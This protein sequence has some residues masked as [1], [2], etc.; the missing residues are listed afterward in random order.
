MIHF[1]KYNLIGVLNTGITLLVVWILYRQFNLNLELSNFLGFVAGGI[2]SYLLNR[3]WNFKSRNRKRKEI[4]RFLL[5]FAIAYGL[6][7]MVLEFLHRCLLPMDFF[8]PF[9]EWISHYVSPG[10]FANIIANIVYVV[11]SFTLYR[12]FVFRV[13][14]N[15]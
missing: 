7:L 15:S 9:R 1:V 13:E 11:V 12:K 14:K 3:I 4:M 8:T 10:Y 5:I 2:N 6:N